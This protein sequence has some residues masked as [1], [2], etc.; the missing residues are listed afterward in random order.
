[1]GVYSRPIVPSSVNTGDFD[2][3][4]V[5]LCVPPPSHRPS[6]RENREVGLH[7]GNEE[8]EERDHGTTGRRD[9]RSRELGVKQTLKNEKA[10]MWGFSS[11]EKGRSEISRD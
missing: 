9:H 2:F 11:G 3:A 6:R 5:P 7:E 1:L 8:N 4:S 10:E